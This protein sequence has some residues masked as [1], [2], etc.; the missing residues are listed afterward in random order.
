MLL[1]LTE[2]VTFYIVLN[3]SIISSSFILVFSVFFLSLASF[4]SAELSFERQVID[5]KISIGYGLAIGDV[6]GDKKPDILLADKSQV[7]WYRNGDWKRFVMAEN[8]NPR[9][10]TRFLDN[11]CIAARD[12]DGDGKV[13][14]AVGANWNPGETNDPTKSGSVHFLIR[15]E[16][17]TGP[18][19]SVK[20]TTHD[21]T[22]HR[23]HWMKINKKSE[24]DNEAVTNEYRLLVLPLHGRGNKGGE[25]EPVRLLAYVPGEKPEEG[26]WDTELVDATFHITHN[27]DLIPFSKETG[28][29]V[30][31]LGGKEGIKG[32]R[33]IDKGNSENPWQSVHMVKNPLSRGVGE[34][35][36]YRENQ[37]QGV[38]A[39][40]EPFHGNELVVYSSS[41]V[42]NEDPQRVS[43]DDSLSQ[44]HALALSDVLGE[45]NQ[46]VIAGWRNPDKNG[47]VGIRIYSQTDDGW[48]THTLDDNGI[49]CEDLKVSDLDGDGKPEIIAAGRATKNVVIYWNRNKKD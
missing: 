27:F 22:V 3:M 28:E 30:I 8:L 34:V 26:N 31:I 48:K 44:G 37:Q 40:I 36:A 33:Y 5:D 29:E 24:S 47:K 19:K 43:L 45:G 9:V 10:V 11:V 1:N 16:D 42:G 13:E 6:D 7:A 23:M 15:P 20:M 2:G 25:G 41:G 12:I 21:P 17:P 32:I 39:A 4:L 49:A 18:W 46:Q 35:R 38:I 14:V